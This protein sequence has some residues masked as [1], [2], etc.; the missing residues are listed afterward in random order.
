MIFGVRIDEVRN[1]WNALTTSYEKISVA[2]QSIAQANE[3]LHLNENYYHV[4]TVT[5]TDLLKAQTLYRQSHDRFVD[6][7]GDYQIKTIEYL[8]ATGR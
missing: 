2:R 7:Y 4:G 3:N 5:I 8:Q 6:A 1:A